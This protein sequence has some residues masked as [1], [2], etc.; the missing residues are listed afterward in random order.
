MTRIPHTFDSEAFTRNARKA[1]LEVKWGQMARDAMQIGL[2]P[3]DVLDALYSFK[4]EFEEVY[5]K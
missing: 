5:I 4:S 2:S 3:E 1:A